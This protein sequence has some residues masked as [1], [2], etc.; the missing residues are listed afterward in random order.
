MSTLRTQPHQAFTLAT[1][2]T[3]GLTMQPQAA[4]PGSPSQLCPSQSRCSTSL[5]SPFDVPFA[6]KDVH[7]ERSFWLL[8]FALSQD[9]K[10]RENFV[11]LQR[12]LR[13]F[14]GN[15]V[16][17]TGTVSW[18]TFSYPRIKSHR[19]SHSTTALLY[20]ALHQ[21]QF[22]SKHWYTDTFLCDQDRCTHLAPRP[23]G[24]F[25]LMAG[26]IYFGGK[27]WHDESDGGKLY[28]VSG[29][30]DSDPR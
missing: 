28:Y 10:D 23:A 14:E 5:F 2:T 9:F 16:H 15:T 3:C 13:R 17:S 20:R 11:P 22:N 29:R 1:R 8:L 18:S 25:Y 4:G 27:L 21:V 24:Y 12:P 19:Q 6:S 30:S 26:G 7:N